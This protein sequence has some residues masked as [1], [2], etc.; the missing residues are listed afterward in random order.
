MERR[1]LLREADP[2][3]A[4]QQLNGM[5]M[6]RCHQ[7]LLMGMITE[8]TPEMIEA[9]V[10]SALETFMAAYRAGCHDKTDKDAQ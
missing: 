8:V 6:S 9:D 1:G 7:Q 2:L 4:A 10:A 3:R 5:C